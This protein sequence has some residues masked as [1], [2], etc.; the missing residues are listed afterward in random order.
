VQVAAEQ[1]KVHFAIAIQE[2]NPLAIGTPLSDV[3]WNT[4]QHAASISR[5]H[6]ISADFERY[7][8]WDISEVSPQRNF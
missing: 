1:V 6:R 2:E 4:L 3:V 7:F 5:H 8:S